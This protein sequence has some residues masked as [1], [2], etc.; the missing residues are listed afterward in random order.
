MSR[1]A[2]DGLSLVEVI[3]AMFL[4]A[5]LSL[6]VLPLLIGGVSLSVTNR[7]VAAATAIAND[8]VAALR[9]GYPIAAATTRTC[10]SLTGDLSAMTVSNVN[11]SAL[12]LRAAPVIDTGET[13]ACPPGAAEYPR[14]VL[15]T[16]VVADADGTLAEVR[17]RITVGAEK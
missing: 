9:L 12:S 2:D 1:R 6:A 5:L 3:I 8:R 4:L 7:D 14:A 10:T 16:V 11:G 17:T 13:L 15:V